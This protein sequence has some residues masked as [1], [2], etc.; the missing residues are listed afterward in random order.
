MDAE[1]R[2]RTME[3]KTRRECAEAEKAEA[4]AGIARVKEMQARIELFKQLKELGL[5]VALEPATN[6]SSLQLHLSPAQPTPPLQATDVWSADEIEFVEH[7]MVIIK[8]PPFN[9]PEIEFTFYRWIVEIGTRVGLGD[10]ICELMTMESPPTTF[11]ITAP[12]SGMITRIYER[13]EFSVVHQNDALAILLKDH[14]Q[15]LRP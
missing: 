6:G 7:N 9:R 3:A 12:W 14:S 11:P 10:Q 2:R 8:C 4:E 15:P 5:S 1:L 13:A